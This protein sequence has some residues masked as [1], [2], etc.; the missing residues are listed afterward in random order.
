MNY[1]I[2]SSEQ[3]ALTR[4]AQEAAARGCEP[5]ATTDYWWACRATKDGRWAL[6]VDADTPDATSIAPEWPVV[7]VMA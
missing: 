5:S 2:F 3:E 6:M 4:S 1:L 7:K